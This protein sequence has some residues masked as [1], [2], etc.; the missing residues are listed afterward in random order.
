[1]MKNV[2]IPR[3]LTEYSQEEL[4]ALVKSLEQDKSFLAEKNIALEQQLKLYEE[5][6]RLNREKKYGASSEKHMSGQCKRQIMPI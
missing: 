1:M 4:I 3:K 5:W 2:K 6:I